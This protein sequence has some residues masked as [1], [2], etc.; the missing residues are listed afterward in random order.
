[1]ANPAAPRHRTDGETRHIE[2]IAPVYDPEEEEFDWNLPETKPFPRPF[3]SQASRD[4]AVV[5]L[6]SAGLPTWFVG[7]GELI[8]STSNHAYAVR[9]VE[10]AEFS[11]SRSDIARFD[12]PA[13]RYPR[14]G[15]RLQP[16]PIE[17]FMLA[18]NQSELAGEIHQIVLR[19][20]QP[21]QFNAEEW[22]DDWTAW[23]FLEDA[24]GPIVGYPSAPE[25]APAFSQGLFLHFSYMDTKATYLR[26]AARSD[27]GSGDFTNLFLNR[28]PNL[29]V[30]A[31]ETYFTRSNAAIAG[32]FGIGPFTVL[33][34][35]QDKVVYVIYHDIAGTD[36]Q[37]DEDFDIFIIEGT[38]NF[39]SQQ[40]T[41]SSPFRVNK[42]TGL[43]VRSDQFMPAA[44]FTVY[45]PDEYMHVAY[46]DTR[47]DLQNPEDDV[48]V[49]LA[50]A[51]ISDNGSSF[52]VEEVICDTEAIDTSY[53][54]NPKFI[55]DRIDITLTLDEKHAV[56]AY[57]GTQHPRAGQQT[58]QQSD[59][60]IFAQVV[61][62][63][64]ED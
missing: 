44:T 58:P 10:E 4:P 35:A 9:A 8:D 39:Q 47:A 25:I 5:A 6:K 11:T 59:E 15:T 61:N 45:G 37:L 28:N 48:K 42:D 51:R 40:Y 18:Q 53:L 43:G 49:G 46:Y 31:T 33:L 26:A 17:V 12:T 62:D 32:D 36:D 7:A 41:W 13:T 16:T 29:V 20:T 38:W 63:V 14:L 3:I 23:D 24:N 57:M 19:S 27:G 1:M 30:G 22:E 34:P 56:I 54:L 50:Y 52:D 64:E 2:Y 60:A 55:G 21:N